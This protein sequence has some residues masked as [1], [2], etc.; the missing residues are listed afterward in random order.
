MGWGRNFLIDDQ[1]FTGQ[2]GAIMYGF[3]NT[4]LTINFIT[5]YFIYLSIHLFIYSF[6]INRVVDVNHS[7]QPSCLHHILYRE[8]AER[9]MI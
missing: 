6:I 2:Q 7:L 9:K 4:D 3:L 8:A 1:F 5:S